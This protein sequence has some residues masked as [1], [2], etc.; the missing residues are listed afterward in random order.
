M[1]IKNSVDIIQLASKDN[2]M[3]FTLTKRVVFT[4]VVK[5]ELNNPVVASV[6][7]TLTMG[8]MLLATYEDHFYQI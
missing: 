7:P 4:I 6:F 3:K 2:A 8:I 5:E 1:D